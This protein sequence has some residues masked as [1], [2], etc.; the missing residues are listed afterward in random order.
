MLRVC[1]LYDN[2]EIRERSALGAI[3]DGFLFGVG[4]PHWVEDDRTMLH[5]VLY[6][7]YEHHDTLHGVNQIK[8]FAGEEGER[9]KIMVWAGCRNWMVES[10]R[11]E[12]GGMNAGVNLI[13][14][15]QT[16]G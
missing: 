15:E 6:S 1:D 8:E 10:Q 16:G 7:D 9:A 14:G 3:V 13:C 2:E 11:I 5:L 12:V 4:I